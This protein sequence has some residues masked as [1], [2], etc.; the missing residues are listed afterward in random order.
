MLYSLF[1]HETCVE[2]SFFTFFVLV[3]TGSVEQL[4]MQHFFYSN[5]LYPP[6]PPNKKMIPNID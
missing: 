1:L 6:P 3:S 5:S 2:V 4:N